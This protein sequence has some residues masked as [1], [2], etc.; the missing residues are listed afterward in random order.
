MHDP[1]HLLLDGD[2]VVVALHNALRGRHRAELFESKARLGNSLRKQQQPLG[3][4]PLHTAV[5]V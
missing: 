1:A 4:L 2:A 3:E 5:H